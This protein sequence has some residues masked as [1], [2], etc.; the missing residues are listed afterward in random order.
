[1]IRPG[2]QTREQI[3]AWH[4][5]EVSNGGDR[6]ALQQRLR[7]RY[8]AGLLAGDGFGFAVLGAGLSASFAAS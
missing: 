7:A 4:R 1:M 5:L 3:S 6:A 8:P 2:S